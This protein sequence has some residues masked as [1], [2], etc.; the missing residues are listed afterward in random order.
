MVTAAFDALRRLLNGHPLLARAQN[1]PSITE[2]AATELLRAG[3]TVFN[4]SKVLNS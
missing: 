4:E 1:T 3:M 2:T